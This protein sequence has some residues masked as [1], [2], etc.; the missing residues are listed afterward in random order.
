MSIRIKYNVDVEINTGWECP[1][2]T[3]DDEEYTYCNLSCDKSFCGPDI[4]DE[5]PAKFDIKKEEEDDSEH[6][7]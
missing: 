1:F 6:K 7:D 4:P 3:Q 2:N 5:C